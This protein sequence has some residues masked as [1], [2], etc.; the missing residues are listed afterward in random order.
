MYR[1]VRGGGS[2]A[3]HGDPWRYLLNT[4]MKY[5]FTLKEGN[6]LS[7]KQ[8]DSFSK[9][10]ICVGREELGRDVFDASEK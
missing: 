4:V 2:L 1:T 6:F 8:T 3:S 10:L 7:S 5:S 9:R